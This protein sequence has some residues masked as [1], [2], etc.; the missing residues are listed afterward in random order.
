MG[1]EEEDSINQENKQEIKEL[2]PELEPIILEEDYKTYEELRKEIDWNETKEKE[3]RNNLYINNKENYLEEQILEKQKLLEEAISLNSTL[4][5]IVLEKEIFE[6]QVLLEELILNKH[7]ILEKNKKMEKHSKL[8]WPIITPGLPKQN[9]GFNINISTRSIMWREMKNANNFIN[10]NINKAVKA[11]TKKFKNKYDG[12]HEDLRKQWEGLI[13]TGGNFSKKY[14]QFLAI[15]CTYSS[16]SE[17]GE[18]FC[19]FSTTRIRLQLLFTIE[20]EIY[21]ICHANLQ[22]PIRDRKKCPKEYSKKGWL[23]I[24]WLVGIDFEINGNDKNIVDQD[25]IIQKKEIFKTDIGNQILKVFKEN[26][27]NSYL[28]R[29]KGV[30]SYKS[31][32]TNNERD[33]VVQQLGFEVKY[34]KKDEVINWVLI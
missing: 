31:K 19:D 2:E 6:K 21:A 12:I 1:K 20:T 9:A 33:I 18:E 13:I 30:Y 29:K 8:V 23:C 17:Y 32:M 3:S 14:D 5:K 34:L 7:S 27:M 25:K 26:V 4:Q 11:K 15:V 16:E 28:P 10:V 24:I 22:K